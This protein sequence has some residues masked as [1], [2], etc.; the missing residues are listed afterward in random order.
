[1]GGVI[2]TYVNIE[3]IQ[4]DNGKTLATWSFLLMLRRMFHYPH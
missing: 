3:L 1:V 4:G 2:I